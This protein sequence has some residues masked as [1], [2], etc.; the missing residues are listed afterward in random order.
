MTQLKALHDIDPDERYFVWSTQTISRER[1]C[2]RYQNEPR[3]IRKEIKEK[4]KNLKVL[5]DQLINKDERLLS[6]VEGPSIV[7][8][9]TL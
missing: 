2:R 3:Q 1:D 9:L 8:F 4:K 5:V 6:L 7:R